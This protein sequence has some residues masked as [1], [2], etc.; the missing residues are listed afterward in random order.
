M[1]TLDRQFYIPKGATKVADKRSDAVA[2][3]YT[4]AAGTLCAVGFHGK[5]QKPDWRYAFRSAKERENTVR[6][7]FERW[8]RVAASRAE[9]RATRSK[10][11]KLQVGHMLVSSWGYEQTNVDF[12][13]VTRV[14]SATMV[15]IR[16]I[17]STTV[18]EDSWASGKCVPCPDAFKGEPMRRRVS[19]GDRVRITDN[20]SARLWD[21]RPMSWT[22]WH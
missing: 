12:Y 20:Q 17:G 18:K 1:L 4:N 14:I 9:R 3:L 22:S 5:A 10:P 6:N 2:Y 7:H 16:A 19:D 21:G 15:E 13:Q 8:Q 11:H